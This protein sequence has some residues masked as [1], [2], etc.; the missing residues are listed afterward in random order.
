MYND[1]NN[2]YPPNGGGGGGGRYQQQ[3]QQQPPRPSPP[4]GHHGYMD[5]DS[6]H[7]YQD[8][9]YNIT[10]N[11]E[12]GHGYEYEPEHVSL[13]QNAQGIPVAAP[14]PT[15]GFAQGAY[16]LS[17]SSSFTHQ[18][19]PAAPGTPG[20]EKK[21][22]PRDD[23]LVDPSIQF[24]YNTQDAPPPSSRYYESYQNL[25]TRQLQ[26]VQLTSG[27]LVLDCPVPTKI[28]QMGRY[29][30]GDEF[31][32]VRY[33]ACTVDPNEFLARR[34]TLRPVLY[35]R[36]TE[37]FI[38]LTMYN[39]DE[40]LF[41]RTMTSVF[42]NIAHLC[43]RTRSRTWGKDGWQK[44]VVAVVSDGRSKINPRVLNVLGAMG[45]YQDGIMQN[46]VNGQ[47]VTSHVFEYT[48]QITVDS[49]LNIRGPDKGMVPVQVLFCLKEKN[50]KKL[51]S[52]R[53][54]FN[55]FAP[56]LNPNVC[57]L[58]DV[59][60]KPGGTS[61]YHLW[62]AFDRDPQVGGACGEICTDVGRGCCNVWNPLVAAQNF[63]YK[64]SNILDKPLES[65]FGYISVLPGAFSA[66]RYAALQ[67]TAPGIGPLAAYFKGEL[68]HSADSDGGIFEANMYLAE[69][70]ILC[71]ELVAKKNC[72]WILKYVKSAKGVTD[73][74]DTLAELI[75]QRR[76]WLNG[77]FF[78]AF[79]A[80]VHWYK[81]FQ[82]GHSILRIFMLLL[83]FFY[84][85]FTLVFS[86]FSLANFY[87]TYYF[88]YHNVMDAVNAKPSRGKDPFFG[89]GK[90]V[91]EIGREIYLL[92]LITIFIISLGN[93]PQGSKTT[94]MI[95]VVLF[96]IV[97]VIMFYTA[98]FMVVQSVKQTKFEDGLSVF[99]DATFRDIVISF[100]ST[101]G[102]YLIS[103]LMYF[104]PWHMFTSFVQYLALLP[105]FI[106]ILTVYA[107]CNVHDVSWGTK[108]D[109]SMSNDLG[110]AKV[111]KQD[112]QEVAEVAVAASQS[113]AN[114]K[115]EKFLQELQKPAPAVNNKRDAAT[116]RE[117]NN[118]LFRTRFL[119]AWMF[120]NALLVVT[121][122]ST[123]FLD[124]IEENYTSSTGIVF[125]PYLSFIFW[126]VAGMAAFRFVGSV[127]YLIL[128]YTFG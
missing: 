22:D 81:I 128:F 39:E 80:M 48:T 24:L 55:A 45:V 112:G 96:F 62:K 38:V 116:K 49:K 8:S 25:R 5:A 75:S 20:S 37:L 15:P 113:D 4:A 58:I 42:K 13:V 67:N 2:H 97:M 88:L 65:F 126:S 104:E 120:T 66:Y 111:K 60:T 110:H 94:Y 54:F 6:V 122:T 14:L 46:S 34:Y 9:Y 27:N 115:Y 124:F 100:A 79:Y 43:S 70:R 63:E 74:P 51:N 16:P 12:G 18:Q 119:L 52:H 101:Y 53:W 40:V 127:L 123:Y 19:P 61:I 78:A 29:K 77:S 93:R 26:Q 114:T 91:Y 68:L 69:D 103:S 17:A 23:P 35:G 90:Y 83:E 95:C 85:L 99:E 72:N 118:K 86:W 121:L 107:F 3:Q 36:S 108:G 82:S 59:G 28:L 98:M 105:S 11:T 125:N 32:K 7:T 57:V 71:F 30:E 44:V 84:N 33:T 106:N 73:V 50:A 41:T 1:R 31:T 102:L 76:R 21:I 10:P 47:A 56:L 117:D 87:L 92:A 89:G 109:T 64:M